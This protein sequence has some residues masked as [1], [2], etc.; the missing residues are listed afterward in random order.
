[1]GSDAVLLFL[2][3]KA[4]RMVRRRWAREGGSKARPPCSLILLSMTQ[5]YLCK[6]QLTKNKEPSGTTLFGMTNHPSG[7]QLLFG[8]QLVCALQPEEVSGS[9]F[10]ATDG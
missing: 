7:Q 10:L 9:S 3:P 6:E 1:V 2:E 8:P 4:R 5:T